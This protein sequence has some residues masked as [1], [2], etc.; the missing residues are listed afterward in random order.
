MA[1]YSGRLWYWSVLLTNTVTCFASA[2]IFIAGLLVGQAFQPDSSM[3]QAGKPDLLPSGEH[4]AGHGHPQ[5]D[6]DEAGQD[7][8]QDVGQRQQPAAVADQPESLPL[9]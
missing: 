2:S 1:A 8:D 3:R 5:Q 7:A 9:E 6:A 4:H